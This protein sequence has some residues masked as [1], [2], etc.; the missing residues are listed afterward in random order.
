MTLRL[1]RSHAFAGPI[2]QGPFQPQ[3]FRARLGEIEVNWIEL[4]DDGQLSCFRGADQRAFGHQR[5]ADSAGNRRG[6]LRVTE[7]QFGGLHRGFACQQIRF[8]WPKRGDGLIVNLF[9]DRR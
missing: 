7:I 5:F 6:D 1:P 4:A 8:I 9:A 2:F 3:H